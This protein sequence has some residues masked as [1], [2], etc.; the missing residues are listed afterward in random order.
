MLFLLRLTEEYMYVFDSPKDGSIKDS[1]RMGRTGAEK[2]LIGLDEV[3]MHEPIPKDMEHFC[4]LNDNKTKLQVG[5]LMYDT[6]TQHAS[7]NGNYTD[8]VLGSFQD[9]RMATK[10]INKIVHNVPEL[11]SPYEEADMSL[12]L[13]AAESAKAGA[14]RLVLLSADTNIRVLKLYYWREFGRKGLNELWFSWL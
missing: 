11:N 13:H 1:E 8:I 3:K 10:V 6:I 7:E 4:P 5:L 9:N 2:P 12:V 14:K